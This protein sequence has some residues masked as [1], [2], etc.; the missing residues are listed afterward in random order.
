MHENYVTVTSLQLFMLT[1]YQVSDKNLKKKL[2]SLKFRQNAQKSYGCSIKFYLA[3]ALLSVAIILGEYINI[4]VQ[5]SHKIS[6]YLKIVEELLA[7][8]RKG[9][10]FWRALYN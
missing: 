7:R 3:L 9:Y 2:C 6:N 8:D 5:Q 1:C 10:F 4:N